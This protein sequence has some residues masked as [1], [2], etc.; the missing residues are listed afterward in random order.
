MLG[1][2]WSN[3]EGLVNRLFGE[4]TRRT[5]PLPS[6]FPAYWQAIL[7]REVSF[8]SRLP[9]DADRS[10]LRSDIFRFIA[11]KTWTPFDIEI[12]DRKKVIIA[13][14]ACLLLNGRI[15]MPV[16][17]RT[18]EIIVR[19]GVFGPRTQSIAPD[20]R[21]FESYEARIGEA[22]YRG[23]IVLSWDAIE[24]LTITTNPAHNVIVHEFA[25]ALDHL[26][27]HTDGTP[28]LENRRALSEW[29]DV[30]TSAFER[31]RSSI[32][33]FL[34]NE[35]DSYGATNPAEFF[36]VV[37]EA[38]FF[39]PTA[40]RNQHPDLFEQMRLFFRQDPSEWAT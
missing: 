21:L 19:S 30:F 23:P 10:Q 37:T 31:L 3:V 16:Y 5:D 36:A 14:H 8:Y 33:D 29:A 9:S 11:E 39:R 20:G 12:D 38:F 7:D 4:K 15:D 22:W 25:H 1:N 32:S 13:A 6:P 24:P 2:L 35:I 26:D 27:G 34:P 17:P 28:P 18:R 40:L